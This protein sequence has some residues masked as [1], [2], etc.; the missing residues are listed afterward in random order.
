MVSTIKRYKSDNFPVLHNAHMRGENLY[1]LRMYSDRARYVSVHSGFLRMQVLLGFIEARAVVIDAVISSQGSLQYLTLICSSVALPGEFSRIMAKT[2]PQAVIEEISQ[3]QAEECI[4]A[5]AVRD[6]L[7]LSIPFAGAV[8]TIHESRFIL[9]SLLLEYRALLTEYGLFVSER[10]TALRNPDPVGASGKHQELCIPFLFF[11]QDGIFCAVPEFQIEKISP[12]GNGAHII[13]LRHSFAPRV[14]V[15]S[16][17]V[18]IKEID[19]LF[20]QFQSRK[21]RGYYQVSVP[22]TGGSFDFTMIIPSFL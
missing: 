5:R 7:A 11:E 3:A 17:L 12:G 10:D 20:C 13:E 8:S 2:A 18:C 9:L 22:V 21:S 16:D 1:Q 4:A 14:L 19:V 6:D 15:C